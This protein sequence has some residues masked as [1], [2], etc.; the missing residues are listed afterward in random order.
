MNKEFDIKT[1]VFLDKEGPKSY[2]EIQKMLETK[3]SSAV[4]YVLLKKLEPLGLIFKNHEGKYEITETGRFVLRNEQIAHQFRLGA[5]PAY[6]ESSAIL[7][8]I[9]AA[10][11]F[12]EQNNRIPFDL[13]LIGDANLNFQKLLDKISVDLYYLPSRLMHQFAEEVGRQKGLQRPDLGA[14]SP[15][16]DN[17]RWIKDSYDFEITLM[18][19]FKP[20][21]LIKSIDWQKTFKRCRNMDKNFRRGLQI[22]RRRIERKKRNLFE[23]HITQELKYAAASN[24]VQDSLGSK[25][26]LVGRSKEEI[27]AKL[28]EKIEK[29]LPPIYE[30]FSEQEIRAILRKNLR[31]RFRIVQT[32]VFTLHEC[33]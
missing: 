27:L 33:T 7:S 10:E 20:R 29:D 5:L 25:E 13:S 2:T 3:S 32:T 1:L 11:P 28:T 19:H 24:P 18:L 8:D 17:L 6:K 30:E 12:L 26:I 21:E 4:S 23:T 9:A 15:C 16:Y 22:A 31:E 14:L